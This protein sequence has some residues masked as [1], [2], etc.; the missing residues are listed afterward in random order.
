MEHV[1]QAAAGQ[2]PKPDNSVED[3]IYTMAC[4]EAAYMSSKKG[5]IALDEIL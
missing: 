3:C 2:I 4:V 5:G 1:M